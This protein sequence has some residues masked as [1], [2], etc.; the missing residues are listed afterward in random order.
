MSQVKTA[1]YC[2]PE[3]M[4][5]DPCLFLVA[6]PGTSSLGL[7][8]ILG[9]RCPRPLQRCKSVLIRWGRNLSC[10]SPSR[11]ALKWLRDKFQ[12]LWAWH[13]ELWLLNRQWL[14]L[15]VEIHGLSFCRR[16]RHQLICSETVWGWCM[17]NKKLWHPKRITG[18]IRICQPLNL[19]ST[20][21]L[22]RFR[23]LKERWDL[24]WSLRKN[25]E[26]GGDLEQL[27]RQFSRLIRSTT[28]W[29]WGHW[30]IVSNSR[31]SQFTINLTLA[32]AGSWTNKS[33]KRLL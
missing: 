32:A 29:K 12:W 11:D 26:L 33:L 13:L 2:N 6:R 25:Q 1:K 4:V 20:V 17:R 16:S 28:P 9:V 10:H 14:K 18:T 3:A 24:V 31:Q 7:T 30:R 8:T 19:L 22:M 21:D 15:R 27:R 23:R 5:A